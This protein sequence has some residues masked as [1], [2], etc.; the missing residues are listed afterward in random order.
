MKKL[1]LVA[2]AAVAMMAPLTSAE[3]APGPRCFGKAATIAGT[4]TGNVLRGTTGPDIIVARAGDD[5]IFSRGG[6]DL[7][8]AGKGDDVIVAAR[9]RDRVRAQAGDDRLDG[10]PAFD[11]LNGGVGTDRCLNGE[12]L[13][14]CEEPAPPTP[15]PPPG[16]PS[17]IIEVSPL[18]MNGWTANE[19]FNPACGPGP[20][21]SSVDFV[22]GPATPPLGTGSVQFSIGPNFESVANIRN[23]LYHGTHIRDLTALEY[24][25]YTSNTTN[26]DQALPF[27]VLNIDTDGVQSGGFFDDQLWVFQAPYQNGYPTQGFPPPSSH[28]QGPPAAG[29]WQKWDALRGGWTVRNFEPSPGEPDDTEGSPVR[30]LESLVA[31]FP[32]ARI[33]NS[34]PGGSGGVRIE[35][36]CSAANLVSN[37]DA[38]TIG[39][40]GV[41]GTFDFE[42]N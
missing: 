11:T 15:V 35:V 3:S 31:Q 13:V 1:L 12:K 39:I 42:A 14:S 18:T 24:W 20:A 30:S 21:T 10:G 17:G 19:F 34:P 4:G 8:C 29:V 23:T 28:A 26:V 37:A 38:L 27:M 25:T 6:R 41:N 5:T 36:G 2:L 40:G 16:P 32:G 33:V 22:T 9:G 7:I